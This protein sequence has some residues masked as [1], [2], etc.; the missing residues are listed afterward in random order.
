MSWRKEKFFNSIIGVITEYQVLA[1]NILEL[2]KDIFFN[3]VPIVLALVAIYL[4]ARLSA[5]SNDNAASAIAGTITNIITV[6]QTLAK[7]WNLISPIL[8]DV[9]SFIN[10]IIEAVSSFLR[11]VGGL[12]CNTFPP[13]DLQRDCPNLAE[14]V[15]FIY[16][17]Y[18]TAYMFIQLVI[19][20]GKVL[21][22]VV[23][24]IVVGASGLPFT[25]WDFFKWI[26][27]F[28]VWIFTDFIPSII[29]AFTSL[30]NE[31]AQQLSTRS[32]TTAQALLTLIIGSA[33]IIIQGLIRLGINVFLT[34][35]DKQFCKVFLDLIH[36]TIYPECTKLFRPMWVDL[37]FFCVWIN[38]NYKCPQIFINLSG[39]CNMFA[40]TCN[41]ENCKNPL[42]DMVPC[43]LNA[44]GQRSPRCICNALY[45]FLP[46]L[47]FLFSILTLDVGQFQ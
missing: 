33:R 6:A 19:A 20:F 14:V 5:G 39:V 23:K 16:L 37:P 11:S 43:V 29:A 1:K 22:E 17:L 46:L 9:G 3:F 2:I 8:A 36:C 13:T 32:I 44:T 45:S 25:W 34:P 47:S 35:I 27:N 18:D 7:A 41:C 42:G 31:V 4:V 15:N 38:G 40:G 28:V 24:A 21:F 10:P 30:F 12:I 26:Y